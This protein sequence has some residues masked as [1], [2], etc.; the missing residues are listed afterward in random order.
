M[1]I[2]NY[3]LSF[4]YHRAGSRM[5]WHM[6][7]IPAL[8]RLRQE[9]HRECKAG[10]GYMAG[11]RLK[12]TKITTTTAG[13]IGLLSWLDKLLIIIIETINI[14][15]HCNILINASNYIFKNAVIYCILTMHVVWFRSHYKSVCLLLLF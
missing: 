9:D 1:T 13:T 10:L 7:V 2:V 15:N 3:F 4:K 8:R 11:T 5:W 6:L 12:E 14:T